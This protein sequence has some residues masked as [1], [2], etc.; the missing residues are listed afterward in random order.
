MAAAV[1]AVMVTEGAQSQ[2][3][4]QTQAR[5]SA[6]APVTAYVGLGSN[7]DDPQARVR[8]ALDALATLPATRLVSASLLYATAPVGPQDQPDYVNAVARLATELTPSDLLAALL[9]IEA[10]QGRQRDGTRWGPRTLDLDLLLHGQARLALAGLHLPHPQIRHRAFVLVPLADVAPPDLN[11]PGQG[12]LGDL[13]R[14]CPADGVR[15][16]T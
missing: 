6:S 1:G 5:P 4:A 15:P 8:R 9:G 14:A 7:L 13:L 2:S 3:Q 16:I 12:I 11:V 10:A